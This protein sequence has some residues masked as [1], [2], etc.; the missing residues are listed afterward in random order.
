MTEPQARLEPP[1]SNRMFRMP[2]AVKSPKRSRLAKVAVVTAGATALTAGL[3]G[4]AN[5]AVL[6]PLPRN[7]TFARRDLLG[8]LTRA[9]PQAATGGTNS[10]PPP[11]AAPVR[12]NLQRRSPVIAGTNNAGVRGGPMCRRPGAGPGRTAAARR[13]PGRTGRYASSGAPRPVPGAP[14]TNGVAVVRVRLPVPDSW[15]AASGT[16]PCHAG[17]GTRRRSATTTRP[18]M[19][20]RLIRAVPKTVAPVVSPTASLR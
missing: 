15:M 2:Q 6:N 5:A 17:S 18:P 12:E 3:T 11:A 10:P 1:E 9:R 20:A 13:A 7:A 4:S 14:G 8:V 19:T 16:G